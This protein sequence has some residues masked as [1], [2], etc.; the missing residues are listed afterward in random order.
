MVLQVCLKVKLIGVMFDLQFIQWSTD[1]VM[2][3][4]VASA[5]TNS[6]VSGHWT[7]VHKVQLSAGSAPSRIQFSQLAYEFISILYKARIIDSALAN[8]VTSFVDYPRNNSRS[9]VTFIIIKHI[10]E[11]LAVEIILRPFRIWSNVVLLS[12]FFSIFI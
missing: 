8:C 3:V 10:W 2:Q 12:D 1:M 7:V 4:G 6:C 9:W 11:W 5:S